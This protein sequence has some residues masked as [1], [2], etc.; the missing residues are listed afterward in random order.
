MPNA[1]VILLAG[2]NGDIQLASTVTDYSITATSVASNVLTVT[3]NY[4]DLYVGQ[5]VYLQQMAE[6]LLNGQLVTSASLT[7]TIA[8]YTGF[9]EYFAAPNYTNPAEV[10]SVE[11]SD[12]PWNFRRRVGRNVKE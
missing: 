8:V 10:E 2:G 11:L 3:V 4:N 1:V 6:S 9:T 5:Q 12:K 7:G